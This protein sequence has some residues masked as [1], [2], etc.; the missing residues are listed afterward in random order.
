M[1]L[2]R[3]VAVGA[4]VAA[5]LAPGAAAH[6][7]LVSSKPAD[8]AVLASAPR[9]VVLAFT[10]PVRPGPGIAAVRNGGGSVLAGNARARGRELV[11]PLRSGLADGVYTVRWRVISDDGH[12]TGGVLAFGVG[13]G[14]AIT[15]S[16]SAGSTGAGPGQYAVRWLFFIGL[17]VAAGAAVFQIVIWRPTLLEE[18]EGEERARAERQE[19][20]SGAVLAAGAF[21][22]AILGA[23]L[24]L[25]L[26]NAGWDT[27]F[28]RVMEIGLG[29]AA[30]GLLAAVG[31]LKMPSIRPLALVAA[32][33]MLPLPSLAGHALDQGRAVLDLVLDVAHVTAA[34]VWI[35]GL[36]AL[37]LALWAGEGRLRLPLARRFSALALAAVV[38]LA[39]TGVGRAL[40]EL[41]S[42]TQ[43]WSTGY[44]RA[45]LVKTGLLVLLAALAACNRLFFLSGP[46]ERLRRGVTAEVVVLLGLVVAVA[47]LTALPPG[48]TAAAASRLRP[49]PLAPSAA[50]LPPRGAVV[51]AKQA[52]SLAV[53]LAAEPAAGGRLRLTAT[54]VSPDNTGVDDLALNFRVEG[55]QGAA[56]EPGSPCGSGCY[57]ATSAD[58]GS[59][60][61]VTVT[62]AGETAAAV[63]FAS[64]R[65]WPA[66]QA[67]ALMRRATARYRA[68][69]SVE[70]RERL[71]SGPR[72]HITSLWKQVAP[73]RLE[74]TI[75]GGA[76]GIL[77]GDKRWD[78]AS[79]RA[80]W[81]KS[82]FQAL[83][84]PTPIWTRRPA[85]ARLL[86]KTRAGY[87]VS[88]LDRSVPAW[89]TIRFD[90]RL[91]PRSLVMTAP[92]HFMHHDYLSFNRPLKI[93]PPR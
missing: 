70:Y 93:V 86:S 32:L 9:E 57:R 37:A 90:R 5:V 7:Y 22:V 21:A 66:P 91:L 35:G 75:P 13:S 59:P 33:A 77:I 53:A 3:L 85:N 19:R 48:R 67:A 26:S 30:V 23:G 73:D 92:A 50:V 20:R 58:V 78:R 44:G 17:L 11:I 81:V 45:I 79:P 52:G 39:G 28:G 87:T 36:A 2:I 55:T 8:R 42:F 84:A 43:L 89:F 54:V 72:T 47:V 31:S 60:T 88:L 24:L 27:R 14:L 83:R 51:L 12:T 34:A 71:A 65:G 46:L 80:P 16:L 68:L 76:A 6:A 64:P 38:L 56:L 49:A 18:L 41:D 62:F 40:E 15:P 82:S 1:R 74:Y 69:E 63:R 25:H 10:E 4:L 29:I 61:A